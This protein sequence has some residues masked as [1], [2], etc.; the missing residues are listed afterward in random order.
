MA[1]SRSKTGAAVLTEAERVAK[2]V[3]L[4]KKRLPYRVI[5]AECGYAEESGARKAVERALT[6]LR[7]ATA[8]SAE[9]LRQLDLAT[10]DELER[11]GLAQAE[12]AHAA[13]DGEGLAAATLSIIRVQQ[14][15]A[16]LMGLDAAE[17]FS[18]TQK[19]DNL[20]A[21]DAMITDLRGRLTGQARDEDEGGAEPR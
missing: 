9:E 11:M 4:R 2:A 8:E 19:T 6:A 21:L 12:A 20:L 7:E 5:A 17:A 1:R 13:G 14:R 16:K 15:R 3:D 18:V 10:L